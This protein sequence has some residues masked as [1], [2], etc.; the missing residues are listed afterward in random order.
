MNRTK[1]LIAAAV[2]LAA[3]LVVGCNTA[4]GPAGAPQVNYQTGNTYVYTEQ[5][6]DAKT[7]QPTGTI[8]TVSSVVLLTNF[9]YQGMANV[10]E[11]QNNHSN[12]ASPDTTYI[13][14]ANGEYWHYNYGLESLNTNQAVLNYNNG[15]RINAGWV[16]QAKLGAAQGTS[17]VASDTSLSVGS[18]NARLVDTA[19]E[20]SDTTILVNGQNV[21][22]Q[23]I[24]HTVD[25]QSLISASGPVD[26]YVSTQDGTVLDVVH[27]VYLG[28]TPA[29]G[30]VT[31]L[32]GTK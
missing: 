14:Q 30:R 22:A 16:L 32:I 11:I 8:D 4:T 5:T 24:I 31:V 7:G 29:P 26:T 3:G 15:K 9:S 1:L 23:H 18:L 13:A 17:W 6:L 20:A 27:P 25:L 19:R 21:T 28:T 2:A 12:G 10:T